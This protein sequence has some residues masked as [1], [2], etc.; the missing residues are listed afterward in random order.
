MRI[1][2]L[3]LT[4]QQT[5]NLR[6]ALRALIHHTK[7][8]NRDLRDSRIDVADIQKFINSLYSMA[9]TLNRLLAEEDVLL[10]DEDLDET[11]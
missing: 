6:K 4:L 2:V 8:V 5:L 7:E 11:S 3:V 10:E 1:E 9:D